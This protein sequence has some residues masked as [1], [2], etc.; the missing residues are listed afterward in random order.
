[1]PYH[2]PTNYWPTTNQQCSNCYLLRIQL[3]YAPSYRDFFT[4][5]FQTIC[6]PQHFQYYI[7]LKVSTNWQRGA[8]KLCCMCSV[9]QTERVSVCN[10][11]LFWHIKVLHRPTGLGC[12]RF[13]SPLATPQQ[14]ARD[15]SLHYNRSSCVTL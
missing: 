6:E 2:Q 4:N 15:Q 8:N 3:R 10:I 9:I 1:M 11:P 7:F 13:V 12:F 5:H 14:L